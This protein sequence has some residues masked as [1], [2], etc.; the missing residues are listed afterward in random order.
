MPPLP[1]TNELTTL[2]STSGA[3]KE[4]QLDSSGIKYPI[5]SLRPVFFP[6]WERRRRG[7]EFGQPLTRPKP[8]SEVVAARFQRAGGGRVE[9]GPNPEKDDAGTL[10]TC[11]HNQ[12]R[13]SCSALFLR[14]GGPMTSNHSGTTR[15]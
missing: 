2:A 1:A 9:D 14:G 12:I 4:T 13:G 15:L 6:A 7:L 8:A 3:I 5:S 11:R 10:E